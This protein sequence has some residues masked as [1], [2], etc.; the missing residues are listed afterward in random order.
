MWHFAPGIAVSLFVRLSRAPMSIR[1]LLPASRGNIKGVCRAGAMLGLCLWPSPFRAR[2]AFCRWRPNGPR[3][4]AIRST[5]AARDQT[6]RC[7]RVPPLCRT[8]PWAPDI[9]TRRLRWT[10]RVPSLRTNRRRFL[11]VTSTSGS[12][13]RPRLCCPNCRR[14]G[15]RS[16]GTACPACAV[17]RPRLTNRLGSSATSHL[18]FGYAL[19]VSPRVDSFLGG[20]L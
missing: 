11:T 1:I 10:A 8:A 7:T 12:I 5:P 2:R 3:S 17:T 9:N 20:H 16:L 4:R 19:A 15:R 18:Q 14:P 13:C 6:A